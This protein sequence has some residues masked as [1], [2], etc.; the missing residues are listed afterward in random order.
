MYWICGGGGSVGGGI[1]SA[2]RVQPTVACTLVKPAALPMELCWLNAGS[3]SYMVYVPLDVAVQ[4]RYELYV[5][6]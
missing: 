6:W 5:F 4:V 3:P 1:G 2:V